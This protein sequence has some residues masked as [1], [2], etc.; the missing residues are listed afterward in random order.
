M[1]TFKLYGNLVHFAAWKTHIGFYPAPSGIAAFAKELSFYVQTKGSVHFDLD[2]PLPITLIKKIVA[3][4]AAEN[5]A[6]YM[7]KQKTVKKPTS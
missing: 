3:Y 5:I 4:R 1:P 7:R 2:R 6:L